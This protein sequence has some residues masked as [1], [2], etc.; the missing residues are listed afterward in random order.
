MK[1]RVTFRTSISVSFHLIKRDKYFYD[2]FFY[3]LQ[4]NR[5][6]SKTFYHEYSQAE[7]Y[8]YNFESGFCFFENENKYV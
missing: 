3:L 1:S 5:N 4:G 2:V 7:A 6:D 8:Y